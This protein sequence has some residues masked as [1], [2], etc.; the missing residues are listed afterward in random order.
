MHRYRLGSGSGASLIVMGVQYAMDYSTYAD[1]VL[2]SVECNVRSFK[3]FHTEC[4]LEVV[5]F[6][7][8]C[9]AP[10]THTMHVIP[11]SDSDTM[12]MCCIRQ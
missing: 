1:W 5:I 9:S 2:V 7:G 3:K 6:E 8:P 10:D 11:A 4:Q 12:H